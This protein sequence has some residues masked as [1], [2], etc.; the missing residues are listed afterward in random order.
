M[1]IQMKAQTEAMRAVA[2]QTGAWLDR[3]R[4]HPKPEER[5]HAQAMVDLL[6]PVVKAWCSDTGVEVASTGIQVHG[7]M[8]FIEETGAAQHLRDARIAPIYEGTNG[9]QANDLIGRKVARDGG[10]A[11]KLFLEEARRAD[12]LGEP[13]A[14]AIETLGKATDWVVDTYG[15]DIRL[16]AVGAVPYLRLF[17]LVAGGWAMARSAAAARRRLESANGS[18]SFLKAKLTTARFYADHLLSQAPS[19]LAQVKNGAAALDLA[20]EQF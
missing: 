7:G 11:A 10:A 13:Y 4:R 3:A 8:G 1:L 16:A 2:Y 12:T 20:E 5:R 15:K 9:V 6:V 14:A 19:L 17:G 18:A